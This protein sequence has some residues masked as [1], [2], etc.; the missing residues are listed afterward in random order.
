MNKC[1]SLLVKSRTKEKIIHR[2]CQKMFFFFFFRLLS[3]AGLLLAHCSKTAKYV[4]KGL[5]G[6]IG[7]E[8]VSYY[9]VVAC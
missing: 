4:V 5:G 9:T 1:R 7:S 3:S 6:I 8:Y 2:V